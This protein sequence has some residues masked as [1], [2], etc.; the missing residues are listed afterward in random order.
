MPH[1]TID[2]IDP[3]VIEKLKDS[4]DSGITTTPSSDAG[5]STTQTTDAGTAINPITDAGQETPQN[6][7]AG[8]PTTQ[9]TDAGTETMPTTDAGTDMPQ[10]T[11]AGTD[12]P[13]TTDAGITCEPCVTGFAFETGTCN[14]VPTSCSTNN[15]GC[16][17]NATCT[18]NINPNGARICT[19]QFGFEGNG[20]D[21]SQC[22]Q[23]GSTCSVELYNSLHGYG[24]A[25][26][27]YGALF[28]DAY[29][30][31]SC[32]E[33]QHCVAIEQNGGASE[34]RCAY[35]C[36]P[37]TFTSIGVATDFVC[38][39][40]V[41]NAGISCVGNIGAARYANMLEKYDD[42]SCHGNTCCAVSVQ[43]NLTCFSSEE[44]LPN[45]A[46]ATEISNFRDDLDTPATMIAALTIGDN[47]GCIQH[48]FRADCWGER[49]L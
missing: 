12:I 18:E 28:C 37:K 32:P 46:S 34:N 23:E 21:Y 11:D 39:T 29:A 49:L 44:T 43:Q 10:T 41:T 9:I 48:N 22:E 15:G 20:V 8:T 13:Q 4:L 16:D 30:Q 31:D 27:G 26:S 6:T 19:C 38:G 25:C 47:H 3:E 14:C 45:W 40:S 7:D 42:I 36:G 1:A 33:G 2:P 17:T 35:L 24:N 5:H